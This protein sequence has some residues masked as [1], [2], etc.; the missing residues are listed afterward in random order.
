MV[1]TMTNSTQTT[2]DHADMWRGPFADAGIPD[3]DRIADTYLLWSNVV[4]G[5]DPIPGETWH[6]VVRVGTDGELELDPTWWDERGGDRLFAPKRFTYGPRCAEA[7]AAFLANPTG[8][9]A[10]QIARMRS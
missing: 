4:P 9:T 6:V 7:L 2:T 5:A 8:E 1:W 10:R 3:P